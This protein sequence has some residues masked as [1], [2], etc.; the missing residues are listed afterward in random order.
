MLLWALK[1]LLRM[2]TSKPPISTW[3][4]NSIP[5]NLQ[6]M[7]RNS[8]KSQRHMKSWGV[9]NPGLNMTPE[10]TNLNSPI[11][12]TNTTITLTNS[13]ITPTS[14]PIPLISSLMETSLTRAGLITM[15]M[16]HTQAEGP[17]IRK[18]SR[19]KADA[20]VADLPHS[21]ISLKTGRISLE[22]SIKPIRKGRLILLF[23]T[24]L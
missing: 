18:T 8:R 4:K 22:G 23:L 2:L 20:T 13:P 17:F 7:K 15:A 5:T 11:T 3:Q 16:T 21:K 24:L 19:P 10:Y 9:R 6:V 14:A 1:A 12:P